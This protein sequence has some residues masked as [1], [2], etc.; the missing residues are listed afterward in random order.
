MLDR[1]EFIEQA[2]SL[3]FFSSGLDKMLRC[4]SY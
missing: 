1:E 2:H 3:E 4:K